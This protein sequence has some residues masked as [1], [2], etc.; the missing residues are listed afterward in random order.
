LKIIE[1]RQCSGHWTGSPFWAE[2]CK[3][4]ENESSSKLVSLITKKYSTNWATFHFDSSSIRVQSPAQDHI[5]VDT[6]MFE[7]Y[8]GDIKLDCISL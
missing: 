6:F 5:S 7:S 4:Q 3:L 1:T 8:A 2:L